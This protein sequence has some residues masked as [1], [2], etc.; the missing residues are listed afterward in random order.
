MPHLLL[1]L[2]NSSLLSIQ[3]GPIVRGW[4]RGIINVATWIMSSWKL[5]LQQWLISELAWLWQT[6]SWLTIWELPAPLSCAKDWSFHVKHAHHRCTIEPK[7]QINSNRSF[8]IYLQCLLMTNINRA[9][10]INRRDI[11]L[12]QIVSLATYIKM[13]LSNQLWLPMTVH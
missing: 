4:W 5:I 12:C 10:N 2:I 11:H 9:H 6:F 3:C 13:K 7:R 8:F 1:G